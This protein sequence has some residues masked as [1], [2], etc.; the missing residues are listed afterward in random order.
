MR[1]K[2]PPPT[3]HFLGQSVNV[4]LGG[5]GGGVKNGP[6]IKFGRWKKGMFGV[7]KFAAKQLAGDPRILVFA[8]GNDCAWA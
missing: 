3:L 5:G 6:S 7:A 1:G 4:G 8:A 2:F